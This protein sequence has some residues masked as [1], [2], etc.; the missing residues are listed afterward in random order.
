[1]KKTMFSLLA[2]VLMVV[3]MV[4]RAQG[5]DTRPGVAVLQFDNG[6]IQP[7]LAPLSKGIQS[8][9][10]TVLA[11]NPRIRVVER[12]NLQKILD[13]QKLGSAD[14]LDPSTVIRVGKLIGARYMITGGFITDPKK[15]MNINVRA[16]DV[17]TG[18]IIYTDG[19]AKGPS[20]N[21]M[22]LI[23]QA[24]NTAN[25]KLNLPQLP[26]GPARDNEE[27]QLSSAKKVPFQAVML[28]SRAIE[29]QDKGDKSG[30]V[31]L[32]KQA[33]DKFPDYDAAKEA[34]KKVQ[35]S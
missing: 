17:E 24:A 8:M 3:P 35:G 14:Q 29:A 28:Y 12:D 11:M 5:S 4:S 18:Q 27:K 13:E 31:Q 26:P 32:Y 22:D 6:S 1:M 10:I 9:M 15:T 34:L 25:T 16:F 21:L 20:D 33:I 2:L 30:A 19:T 7:E 23:A